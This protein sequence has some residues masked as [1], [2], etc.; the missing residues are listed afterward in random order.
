M[1][2]VGLSELLIILAVALIVLGPKK[3][4]EL[5]RNLGRG[6]THLRRAS[7]DLRRSILV[8]E[9]PLEADRYK[10]ALPYSSSQRRSDPLLEKTEEAASVGPA[11]TADPPPAPPAPHRPGTK[12][13]M[14]E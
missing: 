4:P 13:G 10:E 1:L 9:E 6:L 8:E 2:D 11:E 12:Q 3:L 14:N 5:A 7:E